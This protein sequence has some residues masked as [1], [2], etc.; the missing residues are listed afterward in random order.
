MAADFTLLAAAAPHPIVHLN[1]ALNATATVLLVVG[2]A[3]IKRG[4][5]D[6]AQAGDAQCV[7]RVERLFGVLLVVP[8]SRGE[9]AIHASG[10]HPLRL[11]DDPAVAC[12]AGDHGTCTGRIPD[13]LGVSGNGLLRV[14]ADEAKN[15][16][17][18]A[19]YTLRH[20]RLA[21]WTFPIWL[22]VSV[23]G[24]VVYVMLYHL[25]PPAAF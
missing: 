4:R 2:L 7:R 1:A 21:H 16:A 23:T 6:G 9:R 13:L 18:M 19:D 25:W 17:A 3:M 15:R 20:R 24:V 5:V 8:L 12:L 10:R 11:L 14:G 22:Y